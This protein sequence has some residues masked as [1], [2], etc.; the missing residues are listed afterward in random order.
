MR[1]LFKHLEILR[2]T[3]VLI[4]KIK[5]PDMKVNTLLRY[6]EILNIILNENYK[7]TKDKQK[8]F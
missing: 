5:G 4:I 8:N 1:S 7:L 6:L 3:Q 2:L